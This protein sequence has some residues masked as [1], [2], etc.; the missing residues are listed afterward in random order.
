MHAHC[1]GSWPTSALQGSTQALRSLRAAELA[2]LLEDE[3]R[4]ER[5]E[6][7]DAVTPE[8]AADALEEM[9]AKELGSLLRESDPAAAAGLLA[10]MEPDEAAEALRHLQDEDRAELL[11]AMPN[12]TRVELSALLSHESGTAGALMTSIFVSVTAS[13]TAASLRDRLR[14][15]G[16][17]DVDLDGVVVV[18]DQGRLVDHIT[19]LELFLADPDRPVGDLVGEPWHLEPPA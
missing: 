8:V 7:L 5:H 2:D 10:R 9:D 14:T 16:V 18:D 3:G 1:D 4:V 15:E 13:D 6:L 12:E 17:H 19:F 11:G